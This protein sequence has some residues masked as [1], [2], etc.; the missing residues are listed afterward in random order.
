[1]I[2]VIH[3]MNICP[4]PAVYE[5]FS[6]NWGIWKSHTSFRTYIFIGRHGI[7]FGHIE[8]GVV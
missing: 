1:M 6:K 5:A 7:V 8:M 4:M 3:S 2:T